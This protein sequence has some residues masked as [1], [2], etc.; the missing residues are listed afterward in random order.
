[1][2]N[3]TQIT[4]G[5]NHAL[6]IDLNGTIWGWGSGDQNQL[7]RRLFG[8]Q[9]SDGLIPRRIEIFG[10][11][12]KFI[13]AGEFHSL[14]ID[15]KDNVWGWG[16]NNYGQAGDPKTAGTDAALLLHPVKIKHLS[17]R[18]VSML[19]G[20]AHHSVAVTSEGICFA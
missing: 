1:M 17:G 8:R 12:A 5:A 6:A 14:A 13:A 7:G 20:G 3:I 2:K 18:G 19:A 16:L 10:Q 11:K 15:T 9:S 4:C